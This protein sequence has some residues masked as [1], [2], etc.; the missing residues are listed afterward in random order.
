MN[1][2]LLHLPVIIRTGR[3]SLAVLFFF[4]A[5]SV[6]AQTTVTFST[7]GATTWVAPCG[8]TS[9]TVECWGGGGGGGFARTTNSGAGGGGGGGAYARSVIT[10][11]PGNTYNLTVGT[12][13]VGGTAAGVAAANG[14]ASSFN[15]NIVVATGGGA[16]GSVSTNV[17]G[18]AG[19]G[20][21][22]GSTGTQ[23]YNGGNGSAGLNGSAGTNGGGGGGGSAGT[24]SNGNT[25]T[26]TRT[27][28]VAV[29]GGGNGGS[30]GN[31]AAGGNA[32][33]PGGGGAGGHRNTSNRAGGNGG[34]GQVRI[35]YTGYCEPTFTD[36]VEPITNV[37]F[38]G[39]NNTSSATTGATPSIQYFCSMTGNV[40]QGLGYTISLKGNTGGA[41][42]DHFRV[43]VDWNI[44][45]DFIDAGES[46]YIGTITSSSG[47][48]AIALTGTIVVPATATVGNTVM[49]VMKRYDEDPA[50]PCQ[51]GAGYGQAED[52]TITVAAAVPCTAPLAQPTTLVLTPATLTS[53]PVSFTASASA[54]GYLVIQTTTATAPSAPVN[55]TFYTANTAALGGMVA[56]SGSGTSFTATGLIPGTTYWYWVYAYRDICT[57]Q[58]FYLAA[59]PLTGN[60]ST[61][62]CGTILTNTAT[63]TT[64]GIINWSA[65]SWSLGHVPT[66]CENVVITYNESTNGADYLELVIDQAVNIRNLTINNTTGSNGQKTFDVYGSFP[67]VING[68]LALNCTGNNA[69]SE[70]FFGSNGS[71]IKITGNATIGGTAATERRSSFGNYDGS[72]TFNIM[73]NLTFNGSAYNWSGGTWNFDGAGSQTLT[74]NSLIDIIRFE[75]LNIGLLNAP[76]VTVSGLALSP[77]YVTNNLTVNPGATL[78]IPNTFN[79]N[80]NTANT[81]ILTLNANASLLLGGASGGQAGSNFPLDFNTVNL[82]ASS[83]VDY[84]SPA[85][86]NQTVYAPVNYGNLTLSNST[87]SGSSVKTITAGIAGIR[88]NLTINPYSTFS[89]GIF[90][91]N[92][93]LPAGG[94][95][96]MNANSN[97][98]V[99]GTTG[100][101]GANNNFPANFSA[102]NFNE[103]STTT[104]N[105]S[106]AQGI[107]G[108][109]D[110]GNLVIDGSLAKTAP[111]GT[112][113]INGNLT[114]SGN[115]VF[116]HNNATVRFNGTGGQVFSNTSG[117]P[118]LF[119]NFTNNSSG[120]GLTINSD[121]LV[122]VRE[123]LLSSG[124]R[125]NLGTGDIILKSTASSTANVAAIPNEAGIVS[126]P[127]AG[128]FIIERYLPS[129]KAW[130]F[131]ATPV[132]IAGSP[133]ITNS[134][135]EGGSLAS[136]GY[137]TQITGPAGS[138]GMDETTAGY[139]MKWFNM[140]INDYTMVSN[141]GDPVA[142]AAGYMLY[143]R[144]DRA[145]NTAGT[146]SATNLRIKGQLRT[147]SQPFTVN[148]NSFQS[149]GNPYPSAISIASLL[150]AY[151][152]LA[153]AYYAWD[154]SL[155]GSYGVGGY[156]T[157]SS[158]DGFEALVSGSTLYPVGSLHP[159][160]QSGQAFFI[161]NPTGS[162]I[163]GD[164][165]E[166]MKVTG[167]G[168]VSREE[169]PADRQFIRTKLY[170]NT[171]LVADGN[172]VAFDDELSNAIDGDD[173][174]K[175]TNSGE[176][177]GMLRSGKRL[178]VEARSRLLAADTIYYHMTNLREQAYKIMIAP[179]NISSAPVQAYFIDKFLHTETAVSLSDTSW[180]N[181]TVTAAAGSKA[182]DRFM[183]VFKPS[184]I[185][186]VTFTSV[187]AGRNADRSIA[188]KWTVEN[189]VNIVQY[190]VQRSAGGSQ[191]TGILNADA[192]NSRNYSKDDL[193]P[194]AGDN[195]Y[196]IKA[197]GIDGRVQYSNIVKVAPIKSVASVKVYPNPVTDKKMSILFTG[198]PKGIYEVQLLAANGQ[199]VYS[200]A[201]NIQDDNSVQDI[202][203]GSSVAAGSYLLKITT[204]TTL[205]SGQNILV[206]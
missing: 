111:S 43:F 133:S 129:I 92:R 138:T 36:G 116:A 173:A 137:G 69:A 182:S 105:Y 171:N 100:G 40:M 58:P 146:A 160:V 102:Y 61:T 15:T 119:Y 83:T 141:T 27:G 152:N 179:K 23:L 180:I 125:L 7:A 31:N 66:A 110:Y 142:N 34:T 53:I 70:V 185:L 6:T 81:G 5:N 12:G 118:M 73:G 65:L 88:G 11:V 124:S 47:T 132:A 172:M 203:L 167:S 201:V 89:L 79:V 3:L 187:S 155:N 130:R 165:T 21:T 189:E 106:A 48:D 158:L 22:T 64:A 115:S 120:T 134:W 19:L 128:R 149:I 117:Y 170:T 60:N 74:D 86:V 199:L 96:I 123:L 80:Q 196:R 18:A 52:Y 175:F 2:S 30:G 62:A 148:A 13:G 25:V 78:N 42:T 151:N 87:G 90:T 50:N 164:I 68:N 143:V 95:F 183:L 14:T 56:Y 174:L 51:T 99:G 29:A 76:T 44:D 77:V 17:A 153:T 4:I 109:V 1:Q 154:P 46:Y 190:E 191:F 150:T 202:N 145:V 176:N 41:F 101:A 186:P 32:G 39:I 205:V 24:A 193:S 113:T 33:S 194:L 20:A 45:G 10:V 9:V 84:N 200:G 127:G 168:L 59:S 166:A 98:L 85:T 184:V 169:T 104:Y 178:S 121:S 162:V 197:T 55:G 156:Q 198:Q 67:V 54:T 82:D 16:G 26:N 157:L 188:V 93:T 135:R 8:V 57:G 126:Y 91:A 140:A 161:R 195:F 181:I 108:A 192:V 94:N 63:R 49:R 131:I 103:T 72:P 38:A 75:N 144:G 97:L 204:G 163:T 71:T 147:G 28:A 136:T 114:K 206:Q 35:T 107:F 159:D 177:F 112:L 37:T 139:S 122:V